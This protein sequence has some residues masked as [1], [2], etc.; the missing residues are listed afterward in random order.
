MK[1]LESI[2]KIQIGALLIFAIGMFLLA[3]YGGE[4]N[5]HSLPFWDSWGGQ[6]LF[7]MDFQDGKYSELWS[8]HNE[9]RIILTRLLFLIDQ[10]I[11]GGLNIF[12]I[13]LNYILI[14]SS[15][16]IYYIIINKI[17]NK[18][19]FDK[20]IIFLFISGNLFLWTQ[21]ENILWEFQSQFFLAQ[22]LPLYALVSLAQYFKDK[23][24]SYFYLSLFIAVLSVG[25]MANGLIILPLIFIY[26]LFKE[27]DKKKLIITGLIVFIL[28]F[29]YF[30]N[31]TVNKNH[32][33]LTDAILN[34]TINFT[35]YFFI[36]LGN[37]IGNILNNYNNNLIIEFASG[38][39]FF[40]SVLLVLYKIQQKKITRT[41]LLDVL[42]IY[43]FYIMATAF[44]TAG[45]RVNFGLIQ[46]TS[47]R[48]STP[49]IMAWSI[50]III[51]Y[52]YVAKINQNI[53]KSKIILFSFL[54]L[55][56]VLLLNFQFNR[57]RSITGIKDNKNLAT[58][59]LSMGVF[60][61]ERLKTIHPDKVKVYTIKNKLIERNIGS[62]LNQNLALSS[63]NRFNEISFWIEYKN[64]KKPELIRLVDNSNNI[65]GF[66]LANQ[67]GHSFFQNKDSKNVTQISGYILSEFVG[68]KI[69]LVGDNSSCYA[70]LLVQ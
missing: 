20:A 47:P 11:F 41:P 4:K 63:D 44:I 62:G 31:Y 25:T 40:S 60:V 9:H 34:N 24:D 53:S 42:I 2:K 56:S 35:K 37:P 26:L 59:G 19:K 69:T 65:V 39:I 17:E 46:A 49:T 38:I 64:E 67:T 3:I 43:L 36:Y 66:A 13:I 21:Y 61:D 8:L 18:N 12:L 1:N 28:I 5:F 48:Y 22:I 14:M 45:G 70:E 51:M 7:I 58:L 29:L 57:V 6:L 27:K 52:F 55:V 50:L 23:Q 32:G 33:R 16:I 68:S 10:Y 54:I 15:V 30:N